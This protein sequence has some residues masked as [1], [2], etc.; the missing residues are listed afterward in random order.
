MATTG[1][2][3]AASGRSDGGSQ[4]WEYPGRI[5]SSNNSRA[6]ATAL[7]TTKTQYLYG[8]FPSVNVPDNVINIRVAVFIEMKA[9]QVFCY[10]SDV[11]LYDGSTQIGENRG[12]E[13]V[14]LPTSEQVLTYGGEG[15]NWGASTE[16]TSELLN[17]G[18][19]EC[20][21]KCKSNFSLASA[22]SVDS[23]ACQVWWD[24]V[25]DPADNS[26]ASRNFDKIAEGIF[27]SVRGDN[28]TVELHK[29]STYMPGYDQNVLSLQI[30]AVEIET[31]KSGKKDW[32]KPVKSSAAKLT[33][34]SD[35]TAKDQSIIALLQG[36]NGTEFSDPPS[37]QDF[38]M[39]VRKNSDL[40]FA[41]MVKPDFYE[42][43]IA[44][45]NAAFKITAVDF[46][47]L[48]DLPIGKMLVGTISPNVQQCFT[49]MIDTIGYSSELAL[50]DDIDFAFAD[51]DNLL[52][53]AQV[54]IYRLYE[55]HDNA[56]ELLEELCYSFHVEIMQSEGQFRI[57]DRTKRQ[58]VDKSRSE[59]E[60]SS[61][62]FFHPGFKEASYTVTGVAD[63]IKNNLFKDW[64]LSA[65]SI[66]PFPKGWGL[67]SGS[68]YFVMKS[69]D[70]GY[71]EE[72]QY[73]VKLK[74][75]STAL[76]QTVA[77]YTLE[78]DNLTIKIKAKIYSTTALSGGLNGTLAVA[79]LWSNE[80][81][82]TG[83]TISGGRKNEL[84]ETIEYTF[85][86][87]QNTARTIDGETFYE[88]NIS[89]EAENPHKTWWPFDQDSFGFFTIGIGAFV[90]SNVT[91]SDTF[92]H[93]VFKSVEFLL[94]D[95]ETKKQKYK[96]YVAKA[97]RDVSGETLK[98]ES[99]VSSTD[100]YN[101]GAL[102]HSGNINI[103]NYQAFGETGLSHPQSIALRYLG[104]AKRTMAGIE[105]VFFDNV[106][107]H[108]NITF[109]DDVTGER[110]YVPYY[111]KT[112]LKKGNSKVQAIEAPASFTAAELAVVQ[113]SL[114]TN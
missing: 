54:E 107:P 41:G 50:V 10:A 22:F 68:E 37:V 11:E 49:N 58:S 105:G 13:S 90:F 73:K 17:S 19:L 106:V 35:L 72:Y 7:F 55:K 108:K 97:N 70:G 93:I 71:P 83:G 62:L 53:S 9:S 31:G 38:M 89:V 36:W 44:G 30:A 56:Y 65:V 39:V 12:N 1:K 100:L 77:A 101:V 28:Y 40:H 16:L 66:Q 87:Y 6:F 61:V 51:D 29:K 24:D 102:L 104:D 85:G 91:N 45:K 27:S 18:N 5:T 86:S 98:I 4:E 111:V 20:R 76:Q 79:K 63:T 67:L 80:G 59:G 69:D 42:H 64:A 94:S 14:S 57:Y 81:Y 60:S 84:V 33:F 92:D 8:K 88:N 48:K 99:E 46:A 74:K 112:D 47:T 21:L 109:D 3:Y 25:T 34:F 82:A 113:L 32:Y 96:K 2:I 23:V 110:E 26:F 78:D 75:T 43:K 52:S 103:N 95:A 15:D 114:T